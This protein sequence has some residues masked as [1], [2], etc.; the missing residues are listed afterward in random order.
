LIRQAVKPRRNLVRRGRDLTERQRS[1]KHLYQERFHEGLR[2]EGAGEGLTLCQARGPETCSCRLTPYFTRAANRNSTTRQGIGRNAVLTL[3]TQSLNKVV[4]V[5]ILVTL[6]AAGAVSGP[7]KRSAGK[8]IANPHQRR[9][10]TRRV[11]GC[12]DPILVLID[13]FR[14]Q[15]SCQP[16]ATTLEQCVCQAQGRLRPCRHAR[17]WWGAVNRDKLWIGPKSSVLAKV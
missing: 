8:S 3:I 15:S 10:A 4:A 14:A 7:A 17:Y 1:G 16:S 6:S 11:A 5:E 13:L 2:R 12:P 9:T